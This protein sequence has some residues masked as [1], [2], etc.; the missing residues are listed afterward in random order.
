MTSHW[1]E[2]APGEPRPPL[3]D[4]VEV[5]LAVV[6]GGVVGLSTAW[7][8][9][10]AGLSVAVVEAGRIAAGVTGHTTAK[11]SALHSEAYRNVRRAHGRTAARH[12]AESQADAV[13]RVADLSAEL[14][15]DCELE[16]AP[17]FTYAQSDESLPEVREEA[18]AAAEAGLAV[19]LVDRDG[20]TGPPFPVRAAVRLDDQV[21]FHPRKY[22]LGLADDLAA[23]GG[24]VFEDSRVTSVSAADPCVLTTAGGT[25]LRA[26]D[27][28][29]ATHYPILDRALLFAR[30]RPQRELVVTRVIAEAD[31][32]GGMYL[33]QEQRTRSARTAPYGTGR[34]LL[35]VTGEKFTPGARDVRARLERLNRWTDEH[36][37]GTERAAGWA[38]QDNWT[39]DHVPFVGR[40]HPGAR[41]LYV[42]TGF[43]G[44]GISGGVMAGRLLTGLLTGD[45][46]PWAGLYDPRRLHPLRE[47]PHLLQNQAHVV[48]H[49]AGDRL[50]GATAASADDVPRGGGAV[51]RHGTGHV[52]VHRD[53]DG[54][55]HRVRARCTHLGCL[56][57]F[58]DAETTWECPCHG[59]RFDVDGQVLQG[60]AT[61]P[62]RPAD[63]EESRE[64]A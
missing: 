16:R 26:R 55:L 10:A 34:R 40:L 11:L 15:I 43:A 62:L 22:L 51:V 53:A 7:E 29:V 52:A 37:P 36:F 14:G 35:I 31:D 60:P 50:P 28:V 59:S 44:W 57:R 12:F 3:R 25:R 4:G 39:G 46:P 27:V 47:G 20:T 6:G 41:H 13:R 48:R 54:K 30:L 19:E 8:A 64:E 45:E 42:A 58:N 17:A 61:R 38:A 33:T 1:I 5:D 21:Q 49:F 32:P 18:E 9:A 24:L 23:R 56:V 63:G 2:T